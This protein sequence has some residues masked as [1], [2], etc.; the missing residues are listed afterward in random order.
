[1]TLSDLALSLPNGLHDAKLKVVTVDYVSREA[2]LLLDIWMGDIDAVSEA[3]R[4]KYKQA[5]ITLT[6]VIFWVCEP[7]CAG[8]PFFA[9]GWLTIDLGAIKSLAKPPST[10]L[11][12]VPANAFVN[13]I[14]VQ[15]WNAFIY[16][17]AGDAKLKWL[18]PSALR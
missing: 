15:D 16:V 14:F 3:E 12:P 6:G 13:W 1:M 8:Y 5:E 7:P 2:K 4:E 9:N 17:A 10:V 11:P 18:A